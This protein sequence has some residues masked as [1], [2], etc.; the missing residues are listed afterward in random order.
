MSQPLDTLADD[1]YVKVDVAKHLAE[2][3]SLP[4][5]LLK[6]MQL[7]DTVQLV[8]AELEA[9]REPLASEVALAKEIAKHKGRAQELVRSLGPDMAPEPQRDGPER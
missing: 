7:V 1:K 4:P 6:S 9:G 3:T 5:E 2:G 8:T